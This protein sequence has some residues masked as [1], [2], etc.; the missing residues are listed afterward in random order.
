M[1]NSAVPDVTGAA[2]VFA[3]VVVVGVP[4]V[5]VPMAVVVISLSVRTTS[6]AEQ[7]A[8]RVLMSASRKSNLSKVIATVSGLT[9][10]AAVKTSVNSVPVPVKFSVAR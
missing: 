4:A 2:V 5:V 8:V 3:A 6:P 1:V 10:S 7:D 9:F